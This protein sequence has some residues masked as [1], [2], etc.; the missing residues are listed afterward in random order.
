[1]R[2]RKALLPRQLQVCSFLLDLS[3]WIVKL[4]LDNRPGGT[5]TV[6]NSMYTVRALI[7]ALMNDKNGRHNPLFRLLY[8][9]VA[10]LDLVVFVPP[11]GRISLYIGDSRKYQHRNPSTHLEEVI[12]TARCVVL[13]CHR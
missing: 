4:V 2:R 3:R 8:L 5:N 9:Q 10:R 13:A 12:T 7:A 11:D 6:T 1:M